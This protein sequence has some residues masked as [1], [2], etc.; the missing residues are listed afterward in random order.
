MSENPFDELKNPYPEKEEKVMYNL[1]EEVKGILSSECRQLNNL[2]KAGEPEVEA[3]KSYL[4]KRVTKEGKKL[5]L[6]KTKKRYLEKTKDAREK[7]DDLKKSLDATNDKLKAM[8]NFCEIINSNLGTESG[9]EEIAIYLNLLATA[10][11]GNININTPIQIFNQNEYKDIAKTA[12]DV[13]NDKNLT[14]EAK[15]KYFKAMQTIFANNLPVGY[16]TLLL[17]KAGGA[18]NLAKIDNLFN[19]TE[20][21]EANHATEKNNEK[22]KDVNNKDQK[23]D[24]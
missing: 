10:N 2:K 3:A 16:K 4:E 5:I 18:T 11:K 13:L 8:K 14:P 22:N 20:S 23:S 1:F 6:E 9:K 24:R 15:K 17:L 12:N 7:Y 21:W 19:Q